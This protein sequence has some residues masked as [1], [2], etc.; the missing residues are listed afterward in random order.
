VSDVQG[1]VYVYDVMQI[2]KMIAHRFSSLKF[3]NLIYSKYEYTQA[4]MIWK[5]LTAKLFCGSV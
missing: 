3:E 2:S 5:S 1:G 4:V